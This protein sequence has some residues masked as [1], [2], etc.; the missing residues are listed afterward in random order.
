MRERERRL[1][2]AAVVL[3][4]VLTVGYALFPGLAARGESPPDAGIAP[5]ADGGGQ[6]YTQDDVSQMW[7][8]L[9]LGGEGEA[10]TAA[11]FPITSYTYDPYV[12]QVGATEQVSLTV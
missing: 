8:W 9:G 3:L 10:G 11:A 7:T 2:V 6:A 4:V 1:R 5:A 12:L